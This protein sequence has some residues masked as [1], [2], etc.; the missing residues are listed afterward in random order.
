MIYS[1]PSRGARRHVHGVLAA[2]AFPVIL[3]GL[4]AG[5]TPAA[6][7]GAKSVACALPYTT[8]GPNALCRGQHKILYAVQGFT[9]NNATITA[10]LVGFD[11]HGTPLGSIPVHSGDLAVLTSRVS[12]SDFKISSR[13]NVY[14]VTAPIPVLRVTADDGVDK[15]IAYC[16]LV[17]F[18]HVFEPDGT[19]VSQSEGDVTHVLAAIPQVDPAHL[20]LK[21]D[22]VDIL[23]ALGIAHPKDCTVASPCGGSFA[24]GPNT[25]TVSNLVVDAAAINA[26][27]S[28][29]VAFDISG[30]G[31]GGHL[32]AVNGL[33][34]PGAVPRFLSAQCHK[35]PI[36][37]NGLSSGFAITISSPTPGQ[38]NVAVPT[39]VQGEV[40]SGRPIAN[41]NIN[42]IDVSTA[43]QTHIVGNGV[44]TADT[45]K[46]TINTSL[47]ETDLAQD[48]ASQ[49]AAPGTDPGSNVL[50]ASATDDE[51]NRTFARVIFATH[52]TVNPGV[53]LGLQQASQRLARHAVTQKVLAQVQSAALPSTPVDV[54]NAFV[55]G[56][57][58]ASV[59]QQFDVRCTDP[60]SG[61]GKVFADKVKEN[62]QALPVT[63]VDVQ[64]TCSC[65]VNNIPINI[66]SIDI[67]PN[68]ISCPVTF[69]DGK[70]T[71]TLNLP[72][73]TI[74]TS[75]TGDCEDS[76]AGICVAATDVNVSA[77]TTITG[78][79]LSFDITESQI[80]NQT[81]PTPQGV[82]TGT[83]TTTTSGG[84]DLS[85]IGADICDVL[86]TIVTLGQVDFTPEIDVTNV[87]QFTHQVGNTV[88]D[89]IGVTDI[90]IDEEQVANFDQ[91]LSATMTSVRITAGGLLVGLMGSFATT[92]L[93]PDVQ[94][95]PGAL[96]TPAPLP[97]MPVTG[98]QDAF[99]ALAD[100]TLNML[101]ASMTLAG[102]LK[103]SCQPSGQTLGDL[104]PP[105]CDAVTN[106]GGA[107]ATALAQGVCHGIRLHNCET[108]TASNPTLTAQKQGACHGT[109][110]DNCST[111]P[112]PTGFIFATAERNTCSN[113]PNLNLRADQSI[114]LCT[115]QD[116]PPRMALLGGGGA[117]PV[118]TAM[119]LKALSVAQ[120]LDRQGDGLDG[121]LADTPQCLATGA[122]RIG[123]C[124]LSEACLDM[125]FNF[126]MEFH[127]CDGG[128][129]G[130]LS[131]FKE[132]QILSRQAGVLC[133]GAGLATD[134][135]TLLGETSTN[136]IVTETLPQQAEQ[137]APPIC[138]KGL[139][140]SHF[141]TCGTPQ[142]LTIETD[143][144]S[145]FKD[146]L[147]V[148]CK[149]Q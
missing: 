134:D 149:I 140:L 31:C 85:C 13:R 97:T 138:V 69:L 2:L 95:T 17:P 62:I 11:T 44:T 38:S 52:D 64:P 29:T 47:P 34:L 86:L 4:L 117:S 30:L 139:D 3:W 24:V 148:T 128:I 147:G 36:A 8:G 92:A 100:D 14:T 136:D 16:S 96:L 99:I 98:N 21:V 144:D 80:L 22:G 15:V 9:N 67:D 57:S 104:L 76:V 87:E 75:A 65:D 28:N 54:P 37:D 103:T 71:V 88:P 42:G 101:F 45:F 93:D 84:V 32:F 122:P 23:A 143:G 102:K 63:T 33:A 39:P 7:A 82:I 89:P 90:K 19:V 146:Y 131:K 81:T 135:G 125:N 1:S 41:L 141:V 51:G 108:L 40:C 83:S 53:T 133:S 142:L 58:P 106:P 68:Q 25:V 59:Q 10:E 107:A 145:A 55:V 114:L 74:H 78:N 111:I 5:A 120:V 130:F 116:V 112:V 66:T 46:L 73:I 109:R 49:N 118:N 123:D 56:L 35:D 119:R 60:V 94:V 132:V 79:T 26:L 137:F 113:T 12:T 126:D 27:S 72:D 6:A 18:A 61:V 110:G 77:T 129:P 43:G 20:T 48:L 121:D 127:A 115:R 50:I 124:V 70:I 91:T 105:D